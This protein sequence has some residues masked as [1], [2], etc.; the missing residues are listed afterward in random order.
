V[1]IIKKARDYIKFYLN[2]MGYE[3][4]TQ[5][6]DIDGKIKIDSFYINL[7]I[8]IKPLYFSSSGYVKSKRYFN[9]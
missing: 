6:F 7:K 2:R 5:H 9:Y 1:D 8:P 4:L 3:V